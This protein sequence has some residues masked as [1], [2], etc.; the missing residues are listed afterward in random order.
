MTDPPRLSRRALLRAVTLL[1]LLVV[2]VV[3]AVVGGAPQ[4]GQVEGWLTAAG[5]GAP[6]VFV[7]VYALSTLF[8]VPKNVLSILAGLL[9]GMG[10]GLVLVWAAAV[11]GAVTA[12][13][14]GR[15]LGREAVEALTGARVAKVDEVLARHGLLSII[16]VRLVPVLPFTAINYAAGLTA[17]TF[18]AYLLGTALGIIPGT[19]AYVALGAYA[20]E[21]SSWPFVAAAVTLLLLSVGGVVVARRWRAR[22]G[23]TAPG[24]GSW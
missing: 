21:L 18:P 17:V 14:L 10:W 6:L 19:I 20:T 4:R 1:V 13:Q 23:K 3:V 15:S 16:A 11:L 5:P 12:Y 2:V 7:L 22:P 8:P 9:F 24:S